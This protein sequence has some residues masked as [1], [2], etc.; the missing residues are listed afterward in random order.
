MKEAVVYVGVDVAKS[1]LDIDWLGQARVVPND[2]EGIKNLSGW[3]RACESQAHV[4]CEASGGYERALVKALQQDKH[5]VSL[6]QATRVRRYAQ[7]KGILAKT[8][9]IDAK[10]LSAF[11]YA[12]QSQQA[13][14]L[15][16][17]KA[18]PKLRE[19]EAQRRHLT[20]LLAWE[21]TYS[22]Q[23][24]ELSSRRLSATLQRTLKQQIDKLETRIAQL[25]ARDP[26]LA[27]KAQALTSIKALGQR[28]AAL[29]L[30]QMPELGTLN[31]NQISALAGLA[32]FADDSGTRRGQRYIRGGRRSVRS[33]LYMAAL[34]A[35][36]F[37][38]ILSGFYRRLRQNGK[39]PKVALTAT[40]RKL[41]I[42]ANS[43]LKTLP[44]SA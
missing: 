15:S 3:M 34:V 38:P 22:A 14:S 18:C 27:R 1:H 9:R 37:N 43:I 4:I 19:A 16:T 35:T 32:P 24:I 7:A 17:Q 23:L 41:L 42:A 2:P 26:L 40:M 39:P 20:Q 5:Q 28:T 6:V 31:R 33:G 13:P 10:V 30:A 21:K 11:G 12:I 29:L 36:R 25:I 8:D 44:Q